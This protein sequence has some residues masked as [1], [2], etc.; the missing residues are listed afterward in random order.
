M[1]KGGSSRFS[2]LREGGASRPRGY[3]GEL[4]GLGS[5]AAVEAEAS[6]RGGVTT[7]EIA[8][9]MVR[10]ASTTWDRGHW[11]ETSTVEVPPEAPA[12]SV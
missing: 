10:P 12:G 3:L 5:P 9:T 7:S 4:D 6:Q 11:P 1:E 8:P 2:Q